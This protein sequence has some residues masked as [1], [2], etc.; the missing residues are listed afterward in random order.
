M[1]AGFARAMQSGN[2]TADASV[3]DRC[4]RAGAGRR[5]G[6]R[7]RQR[8]R[9][10]RVAGRSRH[11][12]LRQRGALRH[13]HVPAAA[14]P[15]R[16]CR[17]GPAAGPRVPAGGPHDEDPARV[18][19]SIRALGPAVPRR[20]S[21]VPRNGHGHRCGQP[22]GGR[23]L[24]H[25]RGQRLLR[26][27]PA[28]RRAQPRRDSLPVL[29][30]GRQTTSSR[31]RHCLRVCCRSTRRAIG[32]TARTTGTAPWRGRRSSRSVRP[33]C[34]VGSSSVCPSPN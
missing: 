30:A 19:R 6:S 23:C 9:P 5:H 25:V 29:A 27:H 31:F 12:S 24:G 3:G 8:V 7:S 18:D 10:G 33:T 15:V 13:A 2:M 17:P 28:V 11:Q 1:S 4:Q 34:W 21:H 14:G 26:C 22:S 20:R 16:V 32:G